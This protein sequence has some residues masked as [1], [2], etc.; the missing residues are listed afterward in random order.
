M[1]QRELQD[2][3][4]FNHSLTIKTRKLTLTQKNFTPPCQQAHPGSPSCPNTDLITKGSA[5]ESHIACSYPAPSGF[6][7]WKQMLSNPLLPPLF[8]FFKSL[9]LLKMEVQLFCRTSFSLGWYVLLLRFRTCI[10]LRTKSYPQS[11]AVLFSLHPPQYH[12]SIWMIT[13]NED[14]DHLIKV[15]LPGNSPPTL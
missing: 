7:I 5:S 9:T 10:L 6:F 1:P 11:N 15:C 3:P 4:L 14:F 13:G 8:F 12:V 2:I